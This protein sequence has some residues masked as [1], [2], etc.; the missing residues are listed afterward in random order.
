[1]A[2]GIPVKLVIRRIGIAVI[3]VGT[4]GVIVSNSAGAV[5]GS[6]YTDM[7]FPTPEAAIQH[8]TKGVSQ[9]DAAAIFES[10]SIQKYAEK[11]DFVS[12]TDRLQAMELD[13]TLLPATSPMF[14]QLNEALR[15]SLLAGQVRTLIF[16]MISSQAENVQTVVESSRLIGQKPVTSWLL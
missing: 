5:G 8:Y 3:G 7:A 1:M 10:F 4:L 6:R 11:F 16:S 9:G 13:R 15:A 14:K 2:E 12:Y